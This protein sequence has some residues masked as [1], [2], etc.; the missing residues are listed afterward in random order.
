MILRTHIKILLILLCSL[1]I[2]SCAQ[3]YS[4]IPRVHFQKK[5]NTYSTGHYVNTRLQQDE[6]HLLSANTD[7]CDST[8]RQETKATTDKPKRVKKLNTLPPNDST[9]NYQVDQNLIS[10][11]GALFT[12]ATGI[13]AALL[14]APLHNFVF[15]GLLLGLGVLVLGYFISKFIENTNQNRLRP[16][17]YKVGQPKNRDQLKKAFNISMIVSGVSFAL[18]LMT[19]A[20][21]SFALPFTFFILGMITL[22]VGL[23]IGLV[24]LVMGV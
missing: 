9:S 21:G 3:R 7:V 16:N 11:S 6:A 18:A 12:I 23:L 22:W 4:K 13:N 19:A 24:Y 14:I 17:R 8:E 20:T 1:L 15:V 2:A 10:G 5:T